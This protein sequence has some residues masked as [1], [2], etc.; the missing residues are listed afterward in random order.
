MT[1][2]AWSAKKIS[3][4]ASHTTTIMHTEKI[5]ANL[6]TDSMMKSTNTT[7]HFAAVTSA[8]RLRAARNESAEVMWKNGG[9]MARARSIASALLVS[10][11]RCAA[12]QTTLAFLPDSSCCS[13]ADTLDRARG[14]RLHPRGD[15][16]RVEQRGHRHAA[17]T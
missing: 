9:G 14:D 8:P 2:A 1:P 7:C 17:R 13:R 10:S 6:N 12:D 16:L 11:I 15:S 3:I 5:S 4:S